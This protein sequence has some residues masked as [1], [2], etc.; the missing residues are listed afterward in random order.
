MV[1]LKLNSYGCFL[2]IF[3]GKLGNFLFQHLVS[4]EWRTKWAYSWKVVG[5]KIRKSQEMTIRINVW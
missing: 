4:F 1:L 3:G 5:S 2:A